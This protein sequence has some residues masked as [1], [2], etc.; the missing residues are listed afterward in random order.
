MGFLQR[1]KG[2][3]AE[4][5]VTLSISSPTTGEDKAIAPR[6]PVPDLIASSPPALSEKDGPAESGA[7]T[8]HGGRDKERELAPNSGSPE[9]KTVAAAGA[10][11]GASNEETT[12]EEEQEDESVYPGGAALAILTF[13]LCM[14][15][16]VVALDNTIIGIGPPRGAPS[17]DN[18]PY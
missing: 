4:D 10:G 9:E 14:A 7:H 2:N 12:D 15:T 17:N 18:T 11:A 5:A 1:F 3:V 6:A 13:G 8:E 16:F